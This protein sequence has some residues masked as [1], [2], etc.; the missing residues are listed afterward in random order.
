MVRQ[1]TTSSSERIL[2]YEQCESFKDKVQVTMEPN[3]FLITMC[4]QREERTFVV[5]TYSDLS[6]ESAAL[7]G[8][9]ELS[10]FNYDVVLAAVNSVYTICSSSNSQQV[11]T[12]SDPQLVISWQQWSIQQMKTRLVETKNRGRRTYWSFDDVF[13]TC[14]TLDLTASGQKTRYHKSG[15]RGD[16]KSPR[17]LP[18]SFLKHVTTGTVPVGTTEEEVLNESE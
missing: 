14:S 2:M 12:V 9:R 17:P 16:N 13:K 15:E 4:K 7:F 6:T 10:M 8:F 11:F 3:A 5:T 1:Q 18:S